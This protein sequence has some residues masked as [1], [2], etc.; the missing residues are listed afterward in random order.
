MTASAPG[1]PVVRVHTPLC[2]LLGITHP[3][4]LGG[5]AS[6]TAAELVAAVSNAGGIGTLGASG[7]SPAEIREQASRIRALVDCGDSHRTTV[8]RPRGRVRADR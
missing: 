7:R 8:A 1:G 6:G 4:V 3:I 2:E 5:M